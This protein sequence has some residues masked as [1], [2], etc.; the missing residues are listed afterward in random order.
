MVNLFD[1]RT[2]A[3]TISA[4]IHGPSFVPRYRTVHH[5]QGNRG[6][7]MQDNNIKI[8]EASGEKESDWLEDDDRFF[9]DEWEEELEEVVPH[10][11]VEKRLIAVVNGERC[12]ITIEA[13]SDEGVDALTAHLLADRSQAPSGG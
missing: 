3:S 7:I 12:A 1:I 2:D 5:H 10:G 13:P 9:N 4:F 6:K 8:R 11:S